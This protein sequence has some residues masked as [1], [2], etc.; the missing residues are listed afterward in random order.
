METLAGDKTLRLNIAKGK[1]NT[2]EVDMGEPILEPNKIPV[3]IKSD[4]HIIKD[5]LIKAIDKMY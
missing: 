4:E 2:V 3:D 5:L 1:V